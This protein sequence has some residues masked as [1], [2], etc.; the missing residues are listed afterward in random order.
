M[1]KHCFASD[2]YSG[3]APE[4]WQALAQANKGYADAYGDDEWT[5]KAADKIREVFETDCEVFFAFNGT[6]SNALA[7]AAMCQS[8]HS[9]YAHSLSHI[10]TSECGAPEFFSNGSKL[11]TIDGAEGK[12]DADS[13]HALA[14]HRT[15]MHFPKPKVISLTQCTEIG[16]IYTPDELLSLRTVADELNM[17]IHMDGARFANAVAALG[18]SP[19]ALSWQTGVDVLCL[20]G[21]K[22]GMAIGDAIVFF[23]KDLAQDFEYR[24]KQAGQLASKMRY[25]SAPWVAMLENN[26]WLDYAAHANKCAQA[27]SQKLLKIDGISL[28]A[29]TEANGVFVN[30]PTD[31]VQRLRLNGWK[32]YDFMGEEGVRLMCSWATTEEEINAFCDEVS[33]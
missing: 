15:D 14:T 18:V 28:A 3:V 17:H 6:A 20:G 19:K 29:P 10:E 5:A 26:V 25:I 7:L 12:L 21:S 33:A 13:V 16:T 2:N 30:L 32:F 24:C 1:N 31:I 23:N 8:Y 4:A 9:I 22:N 27:L 11:L